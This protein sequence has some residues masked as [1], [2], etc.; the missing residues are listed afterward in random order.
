MLEKQYDNYIFD[1]YGTLIDLNSD[2]QRAKTWKKWC[3]WLDERK[4]KH[5]GYIVFRNDFFK[6]DRL[7]REKQ[8]REGPFEVP[9]IDI[10][11][12]YRELFNRYGNKKMSD[13]AILEASYAFRVSSIEHIRLYTG[14]GEF[15]NKIR[16]RG[17]HAYI[18]SNA[19]ASYTKPE[20]EL[21]GLDKLTDDYL[22]SSDFKCMKPD[23]AFFDII[24]NKHGLDVKKTVMI[25]DSLSSDI[26]GARRAGIDHVHLVG[27]N[28]PSRF[29]VENINNI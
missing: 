20:I 14:V 13:E 23:K 26:E 11:E 1:L 24:I 4:I 27:D 6:A 25:G 19:Q 22:M 29:Y 18:L 7:L 21:F 2:E 9:E 10:L 28:S 5:P 16:K 3:K 12:V 8:L 15:L 17:K